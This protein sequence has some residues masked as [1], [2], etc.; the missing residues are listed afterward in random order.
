MTRT[1]IAVFAL[2]LFAACAGEEKEKPVVAD[3][4]ALVEVSMTSSVGVLLD[5]VPAADRDRAAAQALAR[6]ASD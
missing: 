1:S 4:G 5:E 2:P 6:G 3:P